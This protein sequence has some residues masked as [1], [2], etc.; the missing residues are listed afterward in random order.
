MEK[1]SP[2]I[3]YLAAAAAVC[4]FLVFYPTLWCG[5]INLDDPYYITNNPLIRSLD[6]GAVVRLFT[7]PHLAAWIPLTY[8]SLAIDYHFWGD[9][10]FGYHLTN[11]VMHSINTALVVLLADRLVGLTCCRDQGEG[12]FSAGFRWRYLLAALLA[13]LLWGLHPL[14][15]ESVAWAAERKDVLN[16]LLAL[17]SVL[18][19]LA[20][21]RRRDAGI[22]V[23]APL[24]MLSLVFFVASLLAK[25]VSVTL[26][27]ILLLLDWYLLRGQNRGRVQL[28]IEKIPFFF[29][30]LSVTVT[31]IYFAAT[32]SKLISA[33]EMP[34]YVRVLVSGNAIFEYCRLSIF[35]MG[36]SPYWVLPKPLPYAYLF[37]TVAVC[38]VTLFSLRNMR[39]N[40]GRVA[41]W[42]GFIVLVSPVLA[43]VQAGDDIALAARYTYLPS[44]AF[45]L[46]VSLWLGV[47]MRG[48]PIAASVLTGVTA[49]FLAGSTYCT[50]RLI[51]VWNDT[52]T[53]WSRVI[54][55][56]PAGRAFGDRGVY[57][58]IKG[59]SSEAV[60]DF[61]AAIA[62][63]EGSNRRVL[64]NL[65]A[66]RG[67]ALTDVGRFAEAVADLDR[68][69]ELY[70]HPTYY[71][72]RGTALKTM[73]R[74]AEAE[75][76]F[77]SAGTDPPA[78]DWFEK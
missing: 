52:G 36:I 64:H 16:G 30:A 33:H 2:A 47:Q 42:I 51:G 73:G 1:S 15:M 12:E 68:S 19:Y 69:I 34:L 17:A 74:T 38:A 37:K 43:F 13:G 48:G 6:Y 53:F 66:F 21:T 77:R 56:S 70:P 26:P 24:Y 67:A 57:Y 49:L 40:R 60:A 4:S 3:G 10:P 22:R 11:L 18:A 55:V 72:L 8:L 23:Q 29:V 65:Y 32:G 78:I 7:E 50:H 58:L 54:E 35:P 14:R 5:F 39:C 44:I 59:R 61:T 27:V 31:T 46:A 76:D 9:N 71:Y 45:A 63:A 41:T 25:Q 62:I 75:T 28:L 20:Y